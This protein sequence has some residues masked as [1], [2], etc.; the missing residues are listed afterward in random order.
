M[1][2][3]AS[4]GDAIAPFYLARACE[5]VARAARVAGNG[6][7]MEQRLEEALRVADTLPDPGVK[8]WPV[9][10]PDTLRP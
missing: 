1:R 7:E 2:L 3:A 4:Q 9:N 10:D 6:D 8:K 5:A